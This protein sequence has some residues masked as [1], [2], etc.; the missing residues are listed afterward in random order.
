MFCHLDIFKISDPVFVDR[1]SISSRQ[2]MMKEVQERLK[3]NP[4][5]ICP[6]GNSNG[7]LFFLNIYSFNLRHKIKWQ[8]NG[9]I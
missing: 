5:L 4:A 2:N 9:S 6:E 3:R 7:K 8:S 1:D